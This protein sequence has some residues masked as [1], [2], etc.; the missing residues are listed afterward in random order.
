MPVARGHLRIDADASAILLS[1]QPDEIVLLADGRIEVEVEPLL[2]GERFR[3]LT[4]D[5]EV[6]A[7]GTRFEVA[8]AEGRLRAVFVTS[9][10][11]EVRRKDEA[12]C[13]LDPGKRWT[14]EETK[15]PPAPKR[16]L[17]PAP[18]PRFE[19]EDDRLVQLIFFALP[20]ASHIDK[21]GEIKGSRARRTSSLSINSA[22]SATREGWRR[23]S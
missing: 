7:R 8:A 9:G 13:L 3:I 6:E 23:P 15:P 20:L 21:E 16:A 10:R 1:P 2:P 4:D 12:P 22:G 18:K 11:V 19:R 14:V 17:R 5:T